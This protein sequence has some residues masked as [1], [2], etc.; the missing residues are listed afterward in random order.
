M[1]PTASLTD[2]T[3]FWL[4]FAAVLAALGGVG[5][6]ISVTEYH[7]PWTSAWFIAGAVFCGLGCLAALWALV[8]YAGHKVAGARWCPDPQAHAARADQSAPGRHMG[9]ETIPRR[10]TSA[11]I[12][13][14]AAATSRGEMARW[15]RPVLREMTG[16]LRQ[17][18]AAIERA[19][20]DDSY[21]GVEYEFSLGERW[22]KNRERLAGLPDRADLYDS[23]RDAYSHIGRLRRIIQ[24]SPM[25]PGVEAPTLND[26]L[27]AALR[28]IRKAEAE[29]N[30]EL[31]ELA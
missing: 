30:T 21:K 6:G 16:D 24:G 9:S 12:L 22:E 25:H 18:A 28:A 8:L 5:F 4:A 1:R 10:P 11:A 19:L 27:D 17:A 15:L 14:A 2:R 3:G 29:V 31:S 13:A 20:A 26:D 23:L 7:P